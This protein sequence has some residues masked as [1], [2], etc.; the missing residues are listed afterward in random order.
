MKSETKF[1][2]HVSRSTHQ[3][4]TSAIQLL[5]EWFTYCWFRKTNINVYSIDILNWKFIY[6]HIGYEYCH[7]PFEF[8]WILIG[9]Q[10]VNNKKW[11]ENLFYLNKANSKL[12]TKI[13][14]GINVEKSSFTWQIHAI[15]L[16][17]ERRKSSFI[18]LNSIL[19]ECAKYDMLWITWTS[20][21]WF[22]IDSI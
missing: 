9:W 10:N 3:L 13:E 12:N 2:S 21:E 20:G 18:L 8:I 15:H 22:K 1:T 6:M 4:L 16:W 14:I 5:S 7:P 11:R 19:S 17:F